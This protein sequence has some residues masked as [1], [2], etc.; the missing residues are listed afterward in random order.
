MMNASG[1]PRNSEKPPVRTG[2]TMN[3]SSTIN[4]SADRS[5]CA[6]A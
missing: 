4:A 6:S 3:G 1:I 2:T 5:G